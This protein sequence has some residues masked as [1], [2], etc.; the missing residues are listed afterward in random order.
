M[1]KTIE[2]VCVPLTKVPRITFRGD[3]LS[4]QGYFAHGRSAGDFGMNC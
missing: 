1:F 2:L 3:T 4:I